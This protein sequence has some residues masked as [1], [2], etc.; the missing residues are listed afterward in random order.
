M[1]Q[2]PGQAIQE[3]NRQSCGATMAFS[4][5]PRQA[6][7]KEVAMML[8][9]FLQHERTSSLVFHM[10]PVCCRQINKPC[11]EEVP[12]FEAAERIFFIQ[13]VLNEAVHCNEI[14]SAALWICRHLH[15]KSHWILWTRLA[16][17]A[18]DVTPAQ[19][20]YTEKD[21]TSNLCQ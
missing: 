15:L 4:I 6:I 5:L 13:C 18:D 19:L 16:G 14:Q 12:E 3:A 17:Y 1:M 11:L 10:L 21:L 2:V 7:V 20:C 9:T 8:S